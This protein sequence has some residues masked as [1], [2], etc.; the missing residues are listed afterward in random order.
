MRAVGASTK[1]VRRLIVAEALIISVTATVLGIVIG[2]LGVAKGIIALFNAAGAGFPD[3][4]APTPAAHDHRVGHRRGR[5]HAAVGARARPAGGE[6]PTGRR[7]AARDRLRGTRRQPAA[8]RRDRHH[9]PRRGAVP[10][11]AVP[12]S[13]RHDR[14]DP[15]R[16]W[17]SAGDLPRRRQPLG[18]RRQAG[19]PVARCTHPEAVRCAGPAGT[20]E[21]LALATAHRTHRVGADDRCRAR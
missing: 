14:L 11:R 9:R 2:G 21:R 7:D 20:G 10:G 3:T 19:Q 16:R 15:P 8:H 13:G 1:Q 18:H 17:R 6:D 12:Q 5:R 4:R